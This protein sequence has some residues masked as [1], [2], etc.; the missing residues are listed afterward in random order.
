MSLRL[1]LMALV[2]VG[3]ALGVAA[4]GAFA[5]WNAARS[6]RAEIR[7]AIAVAEQTTRYTLAQLPRAD[8]EP[9]SDL[10]RLDRHL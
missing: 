5:C 7:A 9:R 3:L 10:E 8:G 2:A 1:R 4:G 6:V